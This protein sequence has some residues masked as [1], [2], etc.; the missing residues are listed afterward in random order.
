MNPV[1][2]ITGASQGIGAAIATTFAREIRGVRL[3]LV[4]NLSFYRALGYHEVARHA[5]PGYDEPTWV[6]LEKRL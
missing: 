2:L 6:S 1:V 3:A 4:R 5:H